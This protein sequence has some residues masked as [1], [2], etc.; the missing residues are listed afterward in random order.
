MWIEEGMH[1]RCVLGVDGE[2]LDERGIS[3]LF[4]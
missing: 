1:Q 4:E 3:N 2:D